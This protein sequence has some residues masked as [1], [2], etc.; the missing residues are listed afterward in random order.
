MP[1]QRVS[2]TKTFLWPSSMLIKMFM[3]CYLAK[4]EYRLSACCIE[5]LHAQEFESI[6]KE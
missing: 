2:K 3:P 5:I 4:A 1:P 6:M